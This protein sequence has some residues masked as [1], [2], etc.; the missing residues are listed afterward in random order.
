MAGGRAGQAA[1][2]VAGLGVGEVA[3]EPGAGRVPRAGHAHQL[4]QGQVQ[5]D[6]RGL[7]RPV[8]EAA[9]REEEAHG[10][11]EGVVAALPGRPVILRARLLPERVQDFLDR[12]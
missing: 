2:A 4:V 7:A 8:R 5:L 9:G 6:L 11:F 1:V 10:L 12:G 3:G